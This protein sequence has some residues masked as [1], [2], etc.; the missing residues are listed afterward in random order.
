MD[1][2]LCICL[3]YSHLFT[4]NADSFTV[5]IS[6]LVFTLNAINRTSCVVYIEYTQQ[7]AGGTLVTYVRIAAR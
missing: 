5:A 2:Y 6:A 4:A 1:L 7:I 3:R